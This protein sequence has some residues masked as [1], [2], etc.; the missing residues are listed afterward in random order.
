MGSASA[1]LTGNDVVVRRCDDP[2]CLLA[3]SCCHVALRGCSEL[4]DS[5]AQRLHVGSATIR[6]VLDSLCDAMQPSVR[7]KIYHVPHLH[8]DWARP[9][10]IRGTG[11]APAHICT[12]TGLTPAASSPGRGSPPLA[13]SA[14][15][16]GPLLRHLHRDSALHP[17][18]ALRAAS[19]CSVVP[20]T[21]RA[22]SLCTPSVHR[23]RRHVGVWG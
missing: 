9:C 10:H 7:Q 14:P 17:V 22:A 5:D 19:P 1:P 18:L 11:L 21:R 12:G 4:A 3:V 20:R 16:L 13:A 6:P 8:R 2:C 15:G 23:L